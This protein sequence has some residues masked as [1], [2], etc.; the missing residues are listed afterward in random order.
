MGHIKLKKWLTD[1]RCGHKG[2]TDL[3]SLFFNLFG[4]TYK[5]TIKTL[6]IKFAESTVIRR[7]TNN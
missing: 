6:L 4:I 3:D 1:F 2:C 7:V 5:K